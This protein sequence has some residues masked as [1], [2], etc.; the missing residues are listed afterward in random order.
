[1][2]REEWLEKL[3]DAIAREFGLTANCAVSVGFPKGSG[4]R[5]KIGQCWPN[6][7]S[8]DGRNQVFISPVLTEEAVPHVLLHEM[9]HA[10]VGCQAG[11]KGEF[12]RLAR[13]CGLV[14]PWTATTPSEACKTRLYALCEAIGEPYPHAKLTENE[15]S[16]QKTRLLLLECACGI[17]VRIAQKTYAAA[18][19]MF[20][21]SEGSDKCELVPQW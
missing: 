15:G 20:H 5:K 7:A 1:M 18:G 12:V 6:Q 13:Q 10:H 14:K 17:K 4:G 9:I 3:R 8:A 19:S 21:L 2:T 11:H 16:K